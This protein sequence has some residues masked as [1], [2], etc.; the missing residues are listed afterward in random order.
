[1]THVK[2]EVFYPNPLLV[3]T[4]QDPGQVGHV[5]SPGR[6]SRLGSHTTYPTDREFIHRT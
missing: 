3:L 1:M 2:M 5:R 4:S 6:D